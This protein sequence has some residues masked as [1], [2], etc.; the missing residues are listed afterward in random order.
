VRRVLKDES[1][2]VMGLAVIMVAPSGVRSDN[3]PKI[4]FSVRLGEEPELEVVLA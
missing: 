4:R 3:T 2:M 1:G